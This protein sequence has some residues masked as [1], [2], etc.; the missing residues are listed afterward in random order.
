MRD[1]VILFVHV[2]VNVRLADK[3]RQRRTHRAVRRDRQQPA[4]C[5]ARGPV[6]RFFSSSATKIVQ[7]ELKL[8]TAENRQL[9]S[10]HFEPIA[11]TNSEESV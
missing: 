2:I 10:F 8:I 11:N 5:H 1:V 3:G 9:G 6:N 4:G 7:S